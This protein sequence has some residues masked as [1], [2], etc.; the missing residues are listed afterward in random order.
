[1]K[2][3]V[4]PI[5]FL[6]LSIGSAAIGQPQ[7]PSSKIPVGDSPD[8]GP[9]T[10]ISLVAD[11]KS[12]KPGS[13]FTAGLLMRMQ[14]GWHTYWKNSGEAGLPT[15]IRW[16]LPE[17][18]TAGEI[19]WPLPHKYDESA[20]VLTYGYEIENM[21]LVEFVTTQA[22]TPGST[23]TIKADVNWLECE[24][25]CIPGS[26]VVELILPVSSEKPK[27]DNAALFDRY[28]AQIP[29]R[30]SPSEHFTLAATARDGAVEI[31]LG[32]KTGRR[33]VVVKNVSPDFYP[34]SID[35]IANGRTEVVANSSEATLRIP[36]SS[37]EKLRTSMVF[38]GV[39]VYQMESG[40]RTSVEVEVP[41]SA[42]FC[43]SLPIVGGGSGS[44]LDQK[45]E[46]F[47]DTT[48]TLPFALY[49][50]FALIGGLLLNIMPC[51]LP[52]LAL[53][54]F[55][56][57]RMAGDQPRQV[58]R[59]GIFFSL[60][61]LASFLV[62]AA[63][64]ILLKGAGEQVGW[65]F[66]F[67]EPLFVIAMSALIFAFGLSLFGVFEIGLPTIVAFAGIGSAVERRDKTGKGY[68]ASFA[69]GVFATILAT[70]CTAPF[71]GTALGF[72]FAQPAW[73]TLT[74]FT[75]VAVGMALPYLVLT[76]K[77]A[78][79]K[80]LPKPG[81][82]MVTAKELMGF[83]LMATA[84][85]L[86]YVLGKQLGMEAVIWACAFLLTVAIACWLV[87]RFATLNASRTRYVTTWAAAVVVVVLGYWVF[88]ETILDV[89]TVIAGIP[90][91]GEAV[92]TQNR[93]GIQWQPF[94]LV[95]L[96]EDLSDGR[97]V[98]IDFTADW[99][100]TCKVNEHTVM[101]DEKVVEEFRKSNIV[102][103][104]ADWTNRNPDITKLLAKFGRSGVPLYVI[105]PAGRP[106]EP[107]VLPEVIT[108]GI[109]ID[110]IGRAG[111]VRSASF[112]G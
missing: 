22:W 32:A 50:V 92:V 26:G 53:K 51:V 103:I 55:G 73:V 16:T 109:V 3:R 14:K 86:L 52:V 24:H 112:G 71:L 36:L 76:S 83:L 42:E 59:L 74:I 98:F 7:I 47:S 19:R 61:I 13:T 15:Q 66:Q 58:K 49:I 37:Y 64:V 96:E 43:A 87:G 41:L 48:R 18:M 34:E 77:P 2:K 104:R 97:A 60:G 62:L 81:E 101:T 107:I 5:L 111:S 31:K 29:Q 91:S 1:M 70:P 38:R 10:K 30:Y 72:A 88:L 79:M 84:L 100:L 94:S 99:C 75:S 54:I 89:R 95:K 68:T 6:L 25:L 82:W 110:A 85:W 44:L 65:G 57:V 56:L 23:V 27:R 20:E 102:A 108:T 35:E 106:T 67:Q 93:N 69:E 9:H 80:F 17:G 39:L 46:G 105:F 11:V 8:N 45:F 28:I 40:T 12:I 21:L 33:F 63:L 78:W 90:S 4:F